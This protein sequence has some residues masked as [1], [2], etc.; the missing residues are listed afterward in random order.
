M[1]RMISRF[2]GF[3]INKVRSRK[4]KLL[5]RDI[6]SHKDAKEKCYYNNNYLPS[7]NITFINKQRTYESGNQIKYG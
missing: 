2:K 4:S 5:K 3:S 1:S 7:Q 6:R